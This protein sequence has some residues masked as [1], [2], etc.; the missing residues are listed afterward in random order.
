MPERRRCKC[1]FVSSNVLTAVARSFVGLARAALAER[2]ERRSKELSPPRP[3]HGVTRAAH[4]GAWG[5]GSGGEGGG[6]GE[7]D[8]GVGV[9]IG[10]SEARSPPWWVVL[11]RYLP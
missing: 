4:A 1:E 10:G 2:A 8:E 6:E 5:V 9:G 7:G 11:M 3:L